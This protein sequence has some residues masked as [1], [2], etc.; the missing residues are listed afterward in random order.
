M[1]REKKKPVPPKSKAKGHPVKKEERA[2]QKND[3]S[4]EDLRQV[5]GGVDPTG[6]L[7][8]VNTTGTVTMTYT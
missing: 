2:K 5:S 4:D 3:L 1:S 6:G 8:W 7:G